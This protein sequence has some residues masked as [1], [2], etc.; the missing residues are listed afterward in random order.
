MLILNDVSC[1]GCSVELQLQNHGIV[2]VSQYPEDFLSAQS[3]TRLKQAASN[4]DLTIFEEIMIHE[5]NKFY[6]FKI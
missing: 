4:H 6:L 5:V 1:Y 2:N 3:V